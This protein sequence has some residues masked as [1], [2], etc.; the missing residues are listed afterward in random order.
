[1]RELRRRGVDTRGLSTRQALRVARGYPAG[2]RG[3]RDQNQD[4]ARENSGRGGQ[5]VLEMG[6]GGEWSGGVRRRAVGGSEMR[7]GVGKG[8]SVRSGS[9][10]A[11]I[12]DREQGYYDEG[13]MGV[14][15]SELRGMVNEY[16]T[17]GG[18]GIRENHNDSGDEGSVYT[19]DGAEEDAYSYSVD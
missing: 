5:R 17:R 2:L 19:G 3:D 18:N 6:N 1:M 4:D 8:M 11:T 15:T 14:G 10:G 16:A 7:A 13:G 9:R 12:G